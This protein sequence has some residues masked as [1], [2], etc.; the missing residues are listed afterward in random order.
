M[1]GLLFR[2]VKTGNVYRLVRLN[3]SVVHSNTPVVVYQDVKTNK[4]WVREKAEFE[5]GRFHQEEEK[6]KEE[7]YNFQKDLLEKA[8]F[9]VFMGTWVY[10]FFVRK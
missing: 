2:H 1:S 5:D 4:V 6:E 9:G 8:S 7:P 3:A 10:I